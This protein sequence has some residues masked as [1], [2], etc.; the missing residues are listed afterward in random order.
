MPRFLS[1]SEPTEWNGCYTKSR[2][3][4][5]AAAASSF[6]PPS[7]RVRGAGWVG[8]VFGTLVKVDS[9]ELRHGI[10]QIGSWAPADVLSASDSGIDV[11]VQI[12]ESR[13]L[14]PDVSLGLRRGGCGENR[15]TRGGRGAPFRDG[16]IGRIFHGLIRIG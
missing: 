13:G 14:S 1:E 5:G 2:G 9:G 3:Q 6:D 7:I 12:P 4:G 11:A 8:P 15:A 10:S 16:P